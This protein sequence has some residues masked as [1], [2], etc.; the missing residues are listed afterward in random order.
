MSRLWISILTLVIYGLAQ[1]GVILLHMFGLFDNLSK[2]ELL[3]ANIYTQVGLFIVAAILI[4]I[5]NIFISNPTRL[6]QEPKTR[7]TFI[8]L[9]VL[10]GY[11]AVMIYQIIAGMINMYVLGGPQ[12]SPN[13][14]RL[15]KVAQE[16]PLFIILISVVGPILEEFVFRKVIFGELYQIIHANKKIKFLIAAIVSSV[17]F[18]AAHADPSFFVIYFGMGFIFAGLYT[19]TKRI[20]VP[21]L[22]HMMQNGFVVIIQVLVGPEKLKQMQESTSFIFHFIL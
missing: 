22:V 20:W 14:E 17:I 8:G 1:F 12:T 11:F 21:I 10:G 3:F 6:E 16:I 2:K 19:L 15:M 13:T 18:S 4:S 7:K 5:L 9:W